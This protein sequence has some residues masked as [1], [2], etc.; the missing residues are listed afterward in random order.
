MTSQPAASPLA[1]IYRLVV[2][3]SQFKPRQFVWMIVDD[4]HRNTPV[5]TSEA[6]FRSMEDAYNAGKGALEHWR[7][8]TRSTNPEVDL[9]QPAPAK[10][11]NQKVEMPRGALTS[12]IYSRGN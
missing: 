3:T 12:S 9:A 11:A 2:T 5:Q 6:T 1:S 7:D 8:K 10:K 4:A